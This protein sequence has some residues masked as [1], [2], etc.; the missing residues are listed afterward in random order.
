MSKFT[1]RGTLF[2][3]APDAN[4]NVQPVLA[5]GNYVVCFDKDMGF[6]LERIAPFTL[7][8]KVY[9]D[10]IRQRDRI[11]AT[12]KDRTASTGA[13]LAGEKAAV[14]PCSPRHCA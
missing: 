14:R 5:P 13:L 12:F 4:L 1:Q 11:I 2:F 7:P 8:P 6:F 9:G 3:V 10:T